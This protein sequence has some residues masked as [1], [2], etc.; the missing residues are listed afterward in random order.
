MA[1]PD[2]CRLRVPSWEGDSKRGQAREG[3]TTHLRCFVALTSF[4]SPTYMRVCVAVARFESST[5]GLRA[6]HA[7]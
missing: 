6:P 1:C 4:A 2:S 5:R 3:Q 7:V